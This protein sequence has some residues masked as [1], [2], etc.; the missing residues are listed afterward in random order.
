MEEVIAA[1]KNDIQ[2]CNV[3]DRLIQGN[4][5]TLADGVV[6]DATI[7]KA[8]DGDYYTVTMTF[9]LE[10]LN[11]DS[12]SIEFLNSDNSAK[13]MQWD[14]LS[15]TFE[16][17]DNGLFRSYTID[18]TWTGEVGAAI[19]WFEGSASATNHVYFSYTD[20]DCSMQKELDYLA[21][22]I[23]DGGAEEAE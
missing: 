7:T 18:E 9:D 23:A 2:T 20:E 1:I 4:I 14:S 5:N 19:I 13:N 12:R 8:E 6:S 11:A 22:F 3:D 15:V 21:E 10:K 16:I 17:W